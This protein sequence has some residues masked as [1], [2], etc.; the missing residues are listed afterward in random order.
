[1]LGNMEELL[2]S[3]I[4]K[5]DLSDEENYALI[6]Q[7]S[8]YILV[9][10]EEGEGL[11]AAKCSIQSFIAGL[12]PHLTSIE[13]EERARSMQLIATLLQEK[14]NMST[15]SAALHLIVLCFCQRLSDQSCILPALDALHALMIHY[16][17]KLGAKYN[18]AAYVLN[19]VTKEVQ[20]Q[21]MVQVIRQRALE[22]VDVILNFMKGSDML[23]DS[24]ILSKE[25][26]EGIMELGE[27]EKDPR[28]LLLFLRLH[29]YVPFFERVFQE[30]QAM[31]QK[32]FYSYA[33]YFPITFEPPSNDPYG[34][35]KEALVD[36]LE[37]AFTGT[38][39][40][41]P[42]IIPFLFEQIQVSQSTAA[43]TQGM[44][45]L[46][47]LSKTYGFSSLFAD[48]NGYAED[49]GHNNDGGDG[50]EQ[51]ELKK[52]Q[53]MITNLSEEIFKIAVSCEEIN[54][55]V[56]DVVTSS[57]R[58][59]S[60]QIE[61]DM[62]EARKGTK[63]ASAALERALM[64]WQSFSL[65]LL[66]KVSLEQV[67]SHGTLRGRHAL[68]IAHALASS[69]FMG[70]EATLSLVLPRSIKK[71]HMLSTDAP[72]KINDGDNLPIQNFMS[73]IVT[74]A[75]ATGDSL[76]A[77]NGIK[78][79]S[80]SWTASKFDSSLALLLRAD[81][82]CE[83]FVNELKREDFAKS[84]EAQGAVRFALASLFVALLDFCPAPT[85]EMRQ[86]ILI[87]VTAITT[88]ALSVGDE[89][90]DRVQA[91][92]LVLA[93]LAEKS[94]L[95]SVLVVSLLNR[96]FEQ[97]KKGVMEH[98][99]AAIGFIAS[100]GSSSTEENVKLACISNIYSSS[101]FGLNEEEL[102][103]NRY[104]CRCIA[105]D[106]FNK[107]LSQEE[108]GNDR[109]VSKLLVE[110]HEGAALVSM[111]S[112]CLHGRDSSMIESY[113][114]LLQFL[115]DLIP[116][117]GQLALCD[118][119]IGVVES[120]LPAD[121]ATYGQALYESS[122]SSEVLRDLQRRVLGQKEWGRM[123]LHSSKILQVVLVHLASGSS[124]TYAQFSDDAD[125]S[126]P[127][128]TRVKVQ[129]DTCLGLTCLALFSESEMPNNLATLMAVF[130]HNLPA[131]LLLDRLLMLVLSL[132]SESDGIVP[133]TKL[134]CHLFLLC[135]RAVMARKIA[136][137]SSLSV[138]SLQDKLPSIGRAGAGAV[139]AEWNRM[140]WQQ[141]YTDVFFFLLD[142]NA[143]NANVMRT[144][145]FVSSVHLMTDEEV[146]L[147]AG[148]SA[149]SV[150]WKQR[151]WGTLYKKS[152][153][154]AANQ[155]TYYAVVLCGIAAHLPLA[156]ISSNS[157][158][159]MDLARES[160]VFSSSQDESA[161]SMIDLMGGNKRGLVICIQNSL[162]TME[163]VLGLD[164][165]FE[166]SFVNFIIPVLL[167]ISKNSD[168]TRIRGL[169]LNCLLSICLTTRHTANALLKKEVVK[170]L[171]PTLD[172]RK[173]SVRRLAT[174]IIDA[175]YM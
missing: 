114:K 137:P 75:E 120:S 80:S 64:T 166:H 104:R 34:I 61:V 78:L 130:A 107:M 117:T 157:E 50:D 73:C 14:P 56:F 112:A 53:R 111:T 71:I 22:L 101:Y 98:V 55:G 88:D 9:D 141:I 129:F 103:D 155:L 105:L 32:V 57:L 58:D 8:D 36:S 134:T 72:V 149:A 46:T 24:S 169:A 153:D 12:N 139:G 100:I 126:T 93:A 96:I 160:L 85:E 124:S 91:V 118:S 146:K 152:P 51:D 90:K 27:G 164:M 83:H 84:E 102:D 106:A 108:G 33:C 6:V 163:K 94:G 17:V 113:K 172:D 171:K 10:G 154:F 40:L 31:Q 74:L 142:I 41:L 42:Q 161:H 26:L 29:S 23:N 68:K 89:G 7:M 3:Y 62:R 156:I 11:G 150:L 4:A 47:S 165:T 131:G 109:V 127:A 52:H 87:S 86:K 25:M 92:N 2:H 144:G 69:G 147:S 49:Y 16:H 44:K 128:F 115:F 28:C 174:D 19:A 30:S 119:I 54:D 45:I 39:A 158:Q 76:R 79:L 159:V 67:Q 99:A 95:Y 15:N 77:E 145:Q 82:V 48:G 21:A 70:F 125:Q 143:V 18:D 66:R 63:K 167:K 59:I 5:N 162:L 148:G 140:S 65:I 122:I 133:N 170:G 121:T 175:C 116:D 60:G 173:R 20:I 151:L 43:K 81:Q 110:L 168:V 123:L 13:D 136:R 38:R 135:F 97:V 37:R 138:E 132:A 1:M 35:T